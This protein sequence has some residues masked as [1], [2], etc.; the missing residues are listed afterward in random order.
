M[1]NKRL[2]SIILV[3]FIDLVLIADSEEH[4]HYRKLTES[5]LH[6]LQLIGY[7]QTMIA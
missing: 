1:N 2:F 6:P 4:N 3:V 5:P 7:T